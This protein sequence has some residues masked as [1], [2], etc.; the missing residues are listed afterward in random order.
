MTETP[1]L[2]R[3]SALAARREGELRHSVR[4]TAAALLAFVVAESLALPQG[5][6][7]V[8]TAV[9]VTQ[10]SVG[11][12]V[13]AALDWL[14]STLGGGAYAALVGTVIHRLDPTADALSVAIGLGVAL[15]PLAFLAAVRP[16]FRFAPVTGVIVILVAPV[17]HLSP[18]ES[19]LNRL[20][21]I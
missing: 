3:L 10:A 13:K 16:T 6:W 2:G 20:T 14:I 4:V 9:L 8:F 12:S 15:T 19:A 21:E 18:L 1:A 5:Y 17:Q 7:A 11:G